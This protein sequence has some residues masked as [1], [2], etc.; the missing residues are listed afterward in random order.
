ME[1]QEPKVIPIFD[2][3][4]QFSPSEANEG[5]YKKLLEESEKIHAI[6]NDSQIVEDGS[7][8]ENI[9]EHVDEVGDSIA[10]Q[11]DFEG[12]DE[13]APKEEEQT[14]RH[15]EEES[16][17]NLEAVE[18]QFTDNAQQYEQQ[19]RENYLKEIEQERPYLLQKQQQLEAEVMELRTKQIAQEERELDAYEARIME[20]LNDAISLGETAKHAILIR[21]LAKIDRLREDK[22]NIPQNHQVY[23]PAVNP[24]PMQT[25][26]YGY[27]GQPVQPQHPQPQHIS[28]YLSQ[29]QH[30]SYAQLQPQQQYYQYAPPQQVQ[31][32]Q[33]AYQH[34]L[35][36][37]MPT[38]PS[39]APATSSPNSSRARSSQATSASSQIHPFA[40]SLLETHRI[41]AG[42][43]KEEYM[44]HYLEVNKNIKE[45]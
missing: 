7:G 40:R 3:S 15:T 23:T 43:S 45:K 14:S 32:P 27:T 16:P 2:G 33:Q 44:Q 12:R 28:Q 39:A 10:S 22:K 24:A 11:V 17:E 35:T 1:T 38:K 4:Q 20:G 13:L 5:A 25:P 6:L 8:L 37:Q 18:K 34:P 41:P 36:T 31:Q 26:Y 9:P 21:E 42:M 19:Y 30:P 29:H